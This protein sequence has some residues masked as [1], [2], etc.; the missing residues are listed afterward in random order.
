MFYPTGDEGGT[1]ELRRDYPVS[2]Q[3]YLRSHLLETGHKMART[4]N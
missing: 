1:G 4:A 2:G 3:G